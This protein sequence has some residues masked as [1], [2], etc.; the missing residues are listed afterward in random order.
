MRKVI[1]ESIFEKKTVR[2]SKQKFK[3]NI[4][5]TYKN[6]IIMIML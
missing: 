1:M 4:I 3:V 5:A 6:N 2:I